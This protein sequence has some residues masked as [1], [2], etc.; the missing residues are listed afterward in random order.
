MRSSTARRT[1]VAATIVAAVASAVAA[2]PG[3]ATASV[4]SPSSRF[5]P[6]ARV[7]NPSILWPRG[8]H[9][10]PAESTATPDPNA[11]N[12][13]IYHGGAVMHRPHIYLV[14]WG[15][16]WKQGFRTGPSN[17]YTQKTVMN[18][19]STFYSAIGGTAWHGVQSQYCDGITVGS[20]S[21][22]GQTGARYVQNRTHLLSG[23]WVDSSPVPP[24]IADT[25]LAENL[26]ND[27]LA[28]EAVK[29]AAHFKTTDPDALFMIFT[30][31]GTQALAYG[32][33][34]CAYHNQVQQPGTPPVRYAF[35]PYTPEQGAGCGGNSVNKNNDAFGHGYLDSLTLAG[36]HEFEEAVTDPDNTSG[37]Q[38]GWNDYQT[39]E[40][41]DKC[42]YFHEQNLHVGGQYWAVQPM[43]SNSA[44]KNTGG[45][46][47]APGTGAW[48]VP[49]TV[50]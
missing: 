50:P 19:N 8:V 4:A 16:Q 9:A 39:S 15:A 11:A 2:L 36:G 47:M 6:D 14:Y 7:G 24:V 30:P 35:M 41:G 33:V 45:C 32:T 38:D 34:F 23:T 40:N 20:L 13:L 49:S 18:Y 22:A 43:W 17:Q 42:A 12:N 10:G 1:A 28:T 21:C 46:A 27:P 25:G 26:V 37:V 31:P 5:G 3:S 44:N 48:P 29:A